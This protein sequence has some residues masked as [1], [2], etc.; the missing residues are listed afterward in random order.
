MRLRQTLRSLTQRF[1]RPERVTCTVSLRQASRTRPDTLSR[2]HRASTTFAAHNA[3][4]TRDDVTGSVAADHLRLIDLPKPCESEVYA[5]TIDKV[6][7]NLTASGFVDSVYQVGGVRHPG[8]SDIDLL[9][10]VDDDAASEAN[11]LET[12]TDGE[13]YLFTHSCFVI[14]VSLAPELGTY[15]LMHGYRRLHGTTWTWQEGSGDPRCSSARVQTALEY[16][17]KNLLDLYVQLEYRLVRVRVLLQHLKGLQLD[18]ALL[19]IGDDRLQALMK[20]VAQLIDD[21]FQREDAEQTVAEL[22]TDLLPALRRVV[23][24]ATARHV[25]YSP[26]ES[27]ISFS[28][29]STIESAAA[30]ALSRHGVR[31]P[32]IPGLGERRYFNAHHRL[33]RFRFPLPMIDA[34]SA[35][36][37][38]SRFDYLRRTKSFVRGRFPAFAA[39][40]PPLFYRAL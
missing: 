18:L 13:R 2:L 5:R 11:P 26:C 22:A 19:Q 23:V 6:M 3:G 38:D 35:S 15:A 20:S 29:N 37:H 10:V 34:P 8:I 27:T 14:P 12:L 7:S 33:N 1:Q 30:V 21:W 17:A 36:Y 32:R 28:P 16:L 25:L 39:P 40:I 24:D 4:A 9:V 31:L